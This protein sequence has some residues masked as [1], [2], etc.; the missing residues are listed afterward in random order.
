MG[1]V[2]VRCL[3][4]YGFGAG[5]YIQ[6]NGEYRQLRKSLSEM[7]VLR[8][9]REAITHLTITVRYPVLSHL[10][11]INVDGLVYKNASVRKGAILF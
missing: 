10:V 11:P 4:Y 6:A 9:R 2:N 7:D 3:I 8:E 5:R 1:S